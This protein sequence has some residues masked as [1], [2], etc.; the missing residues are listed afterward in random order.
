MFFRI[1]SARFS[2]QDRSFDSD[3]FQMISYFIITNRIQIF[4]SVVIV[5][6]QFQFANFTSIFQIRQIINNDSHSKKIL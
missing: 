5:L 2:D 1:S 3:Q 4:N 6:F